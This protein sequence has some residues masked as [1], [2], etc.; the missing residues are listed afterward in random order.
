MRLRRAL[1]VLT[2]LSATC[3]AGVAA[4][5]VHRRRVA[6]RHRSAPAVAPA[7]PPATAAAAPAPA[8]AG[9]VVP[10]IATGPS[11][12]VRPD[13]VVLAF[14]RPEKPEP[15]TAPAA[16]PSAAP[17]RCGDNG[18]RTKAGT[19]CAARAGAGGRCRHHPVAA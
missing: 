2:A 19:P 15:T 3:S 9:P 16:E 10:V 7:A 13:A 8:I 17:V 4:A 5:A 6:E 18:G 11:A 14:S 1:T 12:D